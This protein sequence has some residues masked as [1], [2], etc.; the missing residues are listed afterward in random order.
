MST[1]R[2]VRNALIMIA[3]RC[4]VR[5]SELARDFCLSRQR[6]GQIVKRESGMIHKY[7]ELK[8]LYRAAIKQFEEMQDIS[9]EVAKL[10]GEN[11][12]G[13]KP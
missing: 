5:G 7:P 8:E 2:D 4:G 9:R 3:F 12:N 1:N 6:I 13:A 10:A 11:K